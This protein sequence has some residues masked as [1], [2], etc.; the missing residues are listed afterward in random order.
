MIRL[1]ELIGNKPWDSIEF[2]HQMNLIQLLYRLN[3]VRQ[4]YARP[5][6]VTS[7]YRSKEDHF[8]I[9]SEINRERES[10]GLEP[11]RIP[12][13]S[14]HLRGAAADIAD[15]K[16]ELAEW[17]KSNEQRLYEFNLWV[18]DL[19]VTDRGARSWVHFQTLPPRSGKRFF[20][21]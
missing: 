9:Y 17:I 19:S 6:I 10:E 12:M 2:D 18:E 11:L 1:V 13:G 8:R 3:L 7:G 4:L 20:L 14:M 21:P 5:M 15:P 16:R